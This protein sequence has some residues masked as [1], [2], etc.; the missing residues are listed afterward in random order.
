MLTLDEAAEKCQSEFLH[1]GRFGGR[2]R[3]IGTT[4]LLKGL[5]VDHGIFLDASTPP[6]EH[7]YVALTRASKSLTIIWTTPTLNPAE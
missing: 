4:L 1:R 7:L 3:I 2:R 5:E 6:K